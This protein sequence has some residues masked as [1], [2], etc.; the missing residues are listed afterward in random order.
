MEATLVQYKDS[1]PISTALARDTAQKNYR[2]VFLE[3]Q[4]R[5]IGQPLLNPPVTLK[6][7]D[8]FYKGLSQLIYSL[9]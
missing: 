1:S 4:K 8:I 9:C 3:W 2:Y 5:S 6:S 7:N